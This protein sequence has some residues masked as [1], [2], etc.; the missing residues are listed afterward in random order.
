MSTEEFFEKGTCLYD[1]ENKV[2]AMSERHQHFGKKVNGK[3]KVELAEQNEMGP[4][5]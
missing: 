4:T 1:K 2:T 5:C 3:V